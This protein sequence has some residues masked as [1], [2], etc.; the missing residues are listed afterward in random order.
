[1]SFDTEGIAQLKLKLLRLEGVPLIANAELKV[2]ANDLAAL[3]RRMAPIDDGNLEK[4]IKVRYE[5]THIPGLGFVKGGGSYVVYVDNNMPVDGRGGKTVGDYAWEMHE[6]L[7]P[8][9]E[10]KLGDK[11]RLKQDGN[12]NIQ[13]GGWFLTRSAEQMRDA[14]HARLATVVLKYTEVVDIE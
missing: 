1:M 6:H 7:T 10:M 14:V 3:S 13:V 5:G 11:S 12:P 2:C 9:G 4:A 8:A